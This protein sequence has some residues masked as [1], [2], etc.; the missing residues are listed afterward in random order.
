MAGIFVSG[1]TALLLASQMPQPPLGLSIAG[2]TTAEPEGTPADA[3]TL[4]AAKDRI[5]RMTVAVMINGKGPYNFVV[6]TAAD[7]TVISQR[8]ATELGLPSGKTLKVHGVSGSRAVPSVRISSLA[9]GSR[10]IGE[11]NAPVLDEAALGAVGLLGVD[12]L[13]DQRVT[14]D[15]RG[16]KLSVHAPPKREAVPDDVIV[17]TAKRRFGQLIIA[18]A[19][20]RKDK[21]Y[22]IVDSGAQVSIGN[23]ELKARLFHGQVSPRPLQVTLIGVT[24]VE[25][26]ADFIVI[27]EMRIGPMTVRN[28]PVA[29]ADVPPFAL[30]KLDKAPAMLLGTDMLRGF[31]RVAL[32]FENKKVRFVPARNLQS[33][34]S[35]SSQH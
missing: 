25:T 6:D 15:F 26:Q 13:A 17:V 23:S 18:D 21:V 4:A 20:V 32:D 10:D 27:T 1:M 16:D 9:V 33:S 7:R 5:A 22:A 2:V 31:D 8:L 35:N 24:G 34:F 30:F 28:V 3:E 12:A 14:M 29:F 19:A 11:V